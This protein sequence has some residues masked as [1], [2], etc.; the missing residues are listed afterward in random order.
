MATVKIEGLRELGLAMKNLSADIAQ[1]VSHQALSAGASIIKKSAI[2]GAPLADEPYRV[3]GNVRSKIKVGKR[4][5][6]VKSLTSVLVQPGNIKRQIV[7]KRLPA[8]QTTLTSEYIVT[9]RGKAQHGFAS[10]LASLHE[11]GT[12]KMP[13]KP[14]MRP[15]FENNKSR[16]VNAIKDRL[17]KRISQANKA[18]A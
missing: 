1:K 7:L 12:V 17:A 9:V 13:A 3:E 8:S 6:R 18:S 4:T 14:F 2:V 11:F 15:A 5:K 10:R 16:A